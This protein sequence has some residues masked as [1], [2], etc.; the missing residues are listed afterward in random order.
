MAGEASRRHGQYIAPHPPTIG[1]LL[2]Q[3]IKL[4]P[5]WPQALSC[6]CTYILHRRIVLT[7]GQSICTPPG[8]EVVVASFQP[9]E[10]CACDKTYS[11]FVVVVVVVVEIL[12]FCVLAGGLV[13]HHVES[14][15]LSAVVRR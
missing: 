13:V 2:L 3:Y 7:S 6:F 9:S 8:Q 5:S 4:H 12:A 10:I 11:S 1:S 15:G 14:T